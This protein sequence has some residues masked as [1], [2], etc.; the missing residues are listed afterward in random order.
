MGSTTL[1][2]LGKSTLD[3]KDFTN[4]AVK[5]LKV[6]SL[7][8][9]TPYILAWGNDEGFDQVFVQRTEDAV[10]PGEHLA[11]H[12]AVLTRRLDDAAGSRVDDRRDATGLR[13]EQVCSHADQASASKARCFTSSTGPTPEMARYFGAPGSPRC[14]QPE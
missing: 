11:D 1:A 3:R 4:D 13:V 8:D 10:A 6:L 14:A 9:N 2:D 12:V 5:R 7:T